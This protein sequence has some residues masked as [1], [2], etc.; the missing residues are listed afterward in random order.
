ML[1]EK[2]MRAIDPGEQQFNAGSGVG[3]LIPVLGSRNRQ[4]LQCPKKSISLWHRMS[5]IPYATQSHMVMTMLVDVG[6]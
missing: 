1:Q 2:R 5:K 3:T 4:F 6:W